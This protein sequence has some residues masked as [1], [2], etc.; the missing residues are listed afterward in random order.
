MGIPIRNGSAMAAILAGLALHV[1]GFVGQQTR[2]SIIAFLIFTWGVVRLVGGRRW[3]NAAMFPLAFMVFAIPVSVL[4]EIGLP[5]RLWVT[6]AG[7]TIARAAGIDIMRNGTQ[8]IAP[9]GRFNYDVAAPCSGVR[10]LMALTALFYGAHALVHVQNAATGVVGL[11][12][13]LVDL[14][15]VYAP[16]VLLAALTYVFYRRERAAA[17]P[18][19]EAALDAEIRKLEE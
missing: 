16:A 3:G 19:D 10:S 15:S 13:V 7:E 11:G 5:L 1:A 9:D 4:D 6:S 2:I 18:L 12:H 14:P 17:P 8:L